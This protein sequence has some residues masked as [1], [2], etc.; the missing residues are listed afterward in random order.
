MMR[1]RRWFTLL[2]FCLALPLAA[3]EPV[4]YPP[5]GRLVDIGGWQLHLNCTGTARP[6][7]PTVV[8]EAG[9][10]DFSV[11]WSLV[12]PDVAKFARVCSYDRAGTG[13][14]DLGPMPRSMQQIVYELHALMQKGG[15]ALPYILVGHAYGGMLVRLYQTTYAG[16]VS[17]MVLVDA[18]P[19]NP[20][21]YVG[22][23]AMQLNAQARGEPVPP[24]K[25]SG[26]L[27]T[28][29][30]SEDVRI[31]LEATARLTAQHANDPPRDNLPA[32]AQRVRTWALGQWKHYVAYRP[33]ALELEAEEL[34]LMQKALAANPQPL[35]DKP[36]VVLTA[37]L[38]QFGDTE[39]SLDKERLAAQAAM[40]QLSRSSRQVIAKN[41]GHHIHLEEPELVVQAIRDVLTQR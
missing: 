32:E 16:D 39:P 27:R 37:G 18:S 21:R 23:G 38:S 34:S 15:F 10:G 33:G 12:Q 31:Q 24:V 2:A 22:G 17:G 25:T 35:G 4:P 14:S 1:G 3:Q 26:P 41:S 28:S 5:P 11:D 30:L 19:A 6:G 9:L 20:V 36:L 40:T 13:W 29:A 8:L 7:Q